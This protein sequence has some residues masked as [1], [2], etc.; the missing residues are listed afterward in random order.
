MG[1]YGHCHA[2][3]MSQTWAISSSLSSS[4]GVAFQIFSRALLSTFFELRSMT[5]EVQLHLTKNREKPS[6]LQTLGK[7][8]PVP[9][10]LCEVVRGL[11]SEVVDQIVEHDRVRIASHTI[12]S[13]QYL[14]P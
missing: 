1:H 14:V 8:K 6:T 13:M 11:T 7:P 4:N 10:Y 2:F 12:H 5:S 3:H 9:E